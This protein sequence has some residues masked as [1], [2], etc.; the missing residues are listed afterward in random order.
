MQYTIKLDGQELGAIM[1]ALAQFPYQQVAKLIA[2][3][4]KQVNEQNAAAGIVDAVE[5]KGE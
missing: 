2:A 3:I 5:T 1:N 4:E